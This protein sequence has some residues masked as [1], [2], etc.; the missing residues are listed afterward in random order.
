LLEAVMSRPDTEMVASS[1]ARFRGRSAVVTGSGRGIGYQVAKILLAEGASVVINDVN[2]ERLAK[3][4]KSLH[5]PEDRLAQ[6]V[7]DVTDPDAAERLIGTA[8]DRF[9]RLDILVNMVGGSYGA[10]HMRLMDFNLQDWYRVVNLNLTSVF[11]CIRAALPRMRESGGGA[12]VNVSS[13]AG[14]RGEPG[15]WSPIYCAAKAGVQGLTRQVALEYGHEGIRCNC[16]AQ[17]DVLSERT[18]E[19]LTGVESGYFEDEAA[20]RERYKQYPIPRMG[21]PVEVANVICFLASQQASYITGETVL[22][23]GG[24][25]MAP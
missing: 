22:I 11:L 9:G 24:V 18:V 8:V 13:S 2:P 6:A 21:E 4:A 14:V 3:A 20:A 17:G 7:A 16:V 10:P 1:A 25:Y 23:T 12:I 5:Q 19:Y 15:L